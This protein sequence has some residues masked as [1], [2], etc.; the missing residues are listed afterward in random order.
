VD[1][2]TSITTRQTKR[3]AAGTSYLGSLPVGALHFDASLCA[4]GEFAA[5]MRRDEAKSKTSSAMTI[6]AWISTE[7]ALA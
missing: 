7:G 4:A 3:A 5:S 1:F 6:G 2:R